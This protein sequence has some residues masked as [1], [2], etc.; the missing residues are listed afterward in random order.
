MVFCAGAALLGRGQS[1]GVQAAAFAAGT[2]VLAVMAF[3]V[4]RRWARFEKNA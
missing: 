4:D 2:V 3:W 1:S